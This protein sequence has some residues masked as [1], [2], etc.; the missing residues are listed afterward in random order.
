[1]EQSEIQEWMEKIDGMSHLDM[2]KLWRFAPSG[3]PVFNSNLPLFQ[4][5]KERFDSFGGMTPA[6]SKA[7]GWEGYATE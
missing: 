6:I 7:I 5:F 3:H 1:M 2:A 4:H